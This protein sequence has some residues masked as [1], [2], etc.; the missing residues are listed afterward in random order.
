[1]RSHCY[2]C[3]IPIDDS[4]KCNHHQTTIYYRF[5]TAAFFVSSQRNLF[6]LL[7]NDNDP[8]RVQL[9]EQGSGRVICHLPMDS[10]PVLTRKAQRII[11]KLK[12][13]L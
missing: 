9:G 10:Y 5:D 2:F 13:F 6:Y 7:I 4:H 3:N 12:V 1:M 11:A 8:T